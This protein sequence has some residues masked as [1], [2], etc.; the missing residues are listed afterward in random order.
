MEGDDFIIP[1]NNVAYARLCDSQVHV[2]LRR[3]EVHP[4]FSGIIHF[5]T[6][7]KAKDAFEQL[8]RALRDAEAT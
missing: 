8:R 5:D 4:G 3:C 1:V 6:P 7:E 2:G